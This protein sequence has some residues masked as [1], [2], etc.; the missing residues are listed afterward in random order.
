MT[1]FSNTHYLQ[2]EKFQI[3]FNTFSNPS[4][5]NPSTSNPSTSNPS[6]NNPSTK[7]PS[8]SNHNTNNLS[9]SNF[10][11]TVIEENS[12]QLSEMQL[13]TVSMILSYNYFLK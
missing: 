9:T 13:I 10:S 3:N 11:T 1:I 2:S 7:N 5:S 12:N 8:T 6:T 4:T